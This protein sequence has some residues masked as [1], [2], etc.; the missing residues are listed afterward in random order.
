MA[1]GLE[2][3]ATATTRNRVKIVFPTVSQLLKYRATMALSAPEVVSLSTLALD[4][5]DPERDNLILLL[6]PKP[7]DAQGWEA[8]NQLLTDE[9]II[10]NHPVVVFNHHMLPLPPPAAN[11]HV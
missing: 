8:L 6:A 4:P 10:K 11:F 3:L 5:V 1:A 9:D 7:D 2:G